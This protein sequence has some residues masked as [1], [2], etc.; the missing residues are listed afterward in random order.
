VHDFTPKEEGPLNYTLIDPADFTI[1]SPKDIKEDIEIEAGEFIFELPIDFGGTLPNE[2]KGHKDSLM[3]FDIKT[4]AAEAQAAYDAKGKPESF[5]EF[6]GCYFGQI[7][8]QKA[9]EA[10]TGVETADAEISKM[11]WEDK[12]YVPSPTEGFRF[13][14][15]DEL[16]SNEELN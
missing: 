8:V 4:G 3:A 5:K 14:Y 6:N 15:A 7:K 2:Y 11:N 16:L 9:P 1:V 13:V 12:R 10:G